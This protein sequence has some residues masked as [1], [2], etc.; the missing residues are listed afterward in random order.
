MFHSPHGWRHVLAALAALAVSAGTAMP[1]AAQ[2][3]PGLATKDLYHLRTVGDVQLSPDG[4]RVAYGVVT[5]ERPG[6]PDSQVWIRHLTSG[7]VT[8]LGD[9]SSSP[10]F[11]PDGTRLAF[12]GRSGTDSGVFVAGAD[13]AAPQF[14]AP[15]TGTNHPLPSSGERI[16][17]SPDG[18]QIAF[19]SAVAGPEVN[20]NGDPMHITRYLYKPT[21]SEG[22]TRFNDNRRLHIFVADVATKKVR[23][24][25]NGAFYEHSL[26]WSPKG[27]EILFVSN[28]AEPDPDRFF[29]YDVF[30]VNVTN[31]ATRRL[32]HTRSAEY[33]PAWSPD[34]TL[35]AFAGTKR[36]L[37]SSET[38][39]EDTHVWVMKADGSD[40]REI[41]GGI[42]NRQGPPE[43][44]PDG[45]HVYF[46][47]QDRG[48]TRL[49]RL[50]VTG[51]APE[52]I[53][54]DAGQVGSWSVAAASASRAPASGAGDVVAY[55][56]TSPTSPGELFITRGAAAPRALTTLNTALLDGRELAPV[57]SL[58]FRSRDG[59]EV[60]AFLTRP[61]GLNPA[62]KY[63][64]VAMVHGGPHGQQGPAFNTKAQIYA[65]RGL[66]VLMVNYRG[67]TGYGQ[68]H[69]DAIFQDQNGGEA[70][71]VLDG[72]DAALAKYPWLDRD[73]QGVE[74]GSYGGQIADWLI[75][76]TDRF[77]AAIPGWGI[78]N[79]VSFNYMSYYH[80]YLAVEFGG[81][82]HEAFTPTNTARW[83]AGRPHPATIMDLLWE[84]SAIR[85][86]GRVKT[87][88]LFLHGENDNDVPIAESEQ[89]YVAIR[90]VGVPAEMV[91]YPREGHG[92]RE[93]QH[94]EDLITRSLAWYRKYF[95]GPGSTG[96]R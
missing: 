84:R 89:F 93:T 38:T 4:Q 71:D 9:G 54:R 30:A 92:I 48:H 46:T 62:W 43:W 73:R 37:T 17:W 31:G 23:Q 22:N 68:R 34:G 77:K 58:V 85:Y 82:P 32:T 64:L 35:V 18:T 24:L 78:S 55:G 29:N 66:A 81:F 10:R 41:G 33:A 59:L 56:F 6:R 75:T 20:A 76:R 21:A 49:V 50:A 63:P 83:P 19:I 15:I 39:M 1:A 40:R 26:D 51:G 72:L 36:D 2:P 42:D 67:S 65:A 60:E 61:L 11:S 12:V 96:S 88:T 94:V 44:A 5:S 8:K 45:G 87:P 74:G 90:D 79:L 86:V 47:V 53:V 69:A 13:G 25:T 57:D 80:D 7:T 27:D 28:R 95:G 70:E 91:R 52:I 16:A 14:V 3:K